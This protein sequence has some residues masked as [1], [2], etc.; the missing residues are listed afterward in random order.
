MSGVVLVLTLPLLAALLVYL[1]RRWPLPSSGLA[2]TVAL[3]LGLL[4]WSWPNAE[5]VLFL[6]R[7]VRVNAP[8]ALLGQTFAMQPTAQWVLGWLALALAA[9]YLGAWRVSQGRTFFPFGLALLSL[10]GARARLPAKS[11]RKM[12]QTTKSAYARIVSVVGSTERNVWPAR[13]ARTKTE[14]MSMK[15]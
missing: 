11:V 15:S 4:L 12:A 8:V 6:G 2:G 14:R 10:F 7:I 3:A 13:S 9:A 1:L 5:A